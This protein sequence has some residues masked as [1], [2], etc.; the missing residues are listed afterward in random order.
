MG[1]S[2]SSSTLTNRGGGER[3]LRKLCLEMV[4]FFTHTGIEEGGEAMV[5]GTVPSSRT[6]STLSL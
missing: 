2:V 5:T 1:Q 4:P 6:L 3:N